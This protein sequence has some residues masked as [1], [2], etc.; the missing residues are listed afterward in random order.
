MHLFYIYSVKD[1]VSMDYYYKTELLFRFFQEY[2]RNPSSKLY[3]LQFKF[4]TKPF[5]V[6]QLTRVMNRPHVRAISDTKKR[7]PITKWV[8]KH[9]IIE[10]TKEMCLIQCDHFMEAEKLLFQNLR[11]IDRYFF[12]ADY[13]NKQFGWIS[14]QKKEM[15]L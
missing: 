15:L 10:V 2:H 4:I 12:I 13:R 9:A 14:P 6:T 7:A 3:Q 5:P 11:L 8:D 1:E